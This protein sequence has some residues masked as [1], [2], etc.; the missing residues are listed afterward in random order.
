[1]VFYFLLVLFALPVVYAPCQ[2]Y[3]NGNGTIIVE[4]KDDDH[5][6]V[7]RKHIQEIVIGD[8]LKEKYL[9]VYDNP[10]EKTGTELFVLIYGEKVH[11]SEIFTDNLAKETWLKI[12]ADTGKSGWILYY[13]DDPYKNG[14]WEIQEKIKTGSKIWTVRKLEQWLSVWETR[15]NVRD[16]P[17]VDGTKVLFQ[18][19]L[20]SN[21]PQTNVKTLALTEEKETIDGRTDHWAKIV[22]GKGRIGWIF[23]GYADIE[24]GG[25]KYYIPEHDIAFREGDVP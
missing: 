24:H 2:E 12:T 15:L 21:E 17:G 4:F 18:L 11:I 6:Y 13:G 7:V 22:D 19:R 25:P 3:D 8:F 20:D 5:N 16:K 10:N 14:T 9:K 23:A 1:M